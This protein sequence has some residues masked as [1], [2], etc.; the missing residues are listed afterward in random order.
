MKYIALVSVLVACTLIIAGTANASQ[1]PAPKGQF[2]LTTTLVTGF[3]G[4]F[5]GG[6]LVGGALVVPTGKGAFIRFLGNGGV[7][8]P[9][10]TTKVVGTLRTTVLVGAPLSKRFTVLTGAGLTFL[11][12][13]SGGVDVTPVGV[14]SLGFNLGRGIGVFFPTA[15]TKKGI[16]W[17]CEFV[18][19]FPDPNKKS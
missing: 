10:G 17:N 11:F 2:S 7:L 16:V 8:N 6:G 15:V 1:P 13:P 9:T 5:V 19:T 18:L 3:D 14:V 12:P 4:S